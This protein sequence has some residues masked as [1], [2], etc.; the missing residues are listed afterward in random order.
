MKQQKEFLER[1][2]TETDRFRVSF[3]E[4]RILK[5]PTEKIHMKNESIETAYNRDLK[6]FLIFG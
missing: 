4:A 5:K 2:L 3:A 6:H 1:Y